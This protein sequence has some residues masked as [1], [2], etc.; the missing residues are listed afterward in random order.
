MAH[1][2]CKDLGIYF[3]TVL[4]H[5]IL[6]LR[7][8]LLNSFTNSFLAVPTVLFFSI[9]PLPLCIFS[10]ASCQVSPYF[11]PGFLAIFIHLPE[12]ECILL[13][14]SLKPNFWFLER[15]LWRIFFRDR[16]EKQVF[17][18]YLIILIIFLF[19]V[20]FLWN[21]ENCFPIS[22]QGDS[23]GLKVKCQ[24]GAPFLF[25]RGGSISNL[26]LLLFTFFFLLFRTRFLTVVA[27]CSFGLKQKK[28][29]ERRPFLFWGGVFEA[30][31]WNPSISQCRDVAGVWREPLIA[32]L[33]LR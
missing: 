24:K 17:F 8:L 9:F 12:T 29:I 32:P 20:R 18:S 27:R 15:K 23:V 4:S 16:I 28:I 1:P 31:W 5:P 13:L 11:F 30:S 19:N 10:D 22:L 3:R 33:C 6:S 21:L 14:V 25:M 2:A 7:L 26:P